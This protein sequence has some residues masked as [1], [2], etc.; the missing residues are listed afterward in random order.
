MKLLMS[1]LLALS[2]G[3]DLF[4]ATCGNDGFSIT[5]DSA[6]LASDY[7]LYAVTDFFVGGTTATAKSTDADCLFTTTSKTVAFDACGT[8][9][10][11]ATAT[12]KFFYNTKVQAIDAG[13]VIVRFPQFEISVSC[14]VSNEVE[15]SADSTAVVGDPVTI[16]G[17]DETV[18]LSTHFALEV[19]DSAGNTVD[20]DGDAIIFELGDDAKISLEDLH[21]NTD[22]IIYGKLG[23]CW[24]TAVS[25]STA[26]DPRLEITDA[27]GDIVAD[28]SSWMTIDASKKIIS[29][30]MFHFLGESTNYFHCKV[31]VTPDNTRRRRRDAADRSDVISSDGVKVVDQGKENAAHPTCA[32][33]GLA[34]LTLGALY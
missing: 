16:T 8:V 21:P 27:S 7:E 11:T 18:D 31:I 4:S 25:D 30:K 20:G 2:S 28:V 32:A 6:C 23:Q 24:A 13:G 3:C 14:Q 19:Q 34:F 26:T 22:D 9:T 17:I 1:A 5:V 15:S 29:F 12:D 10:D 33:L